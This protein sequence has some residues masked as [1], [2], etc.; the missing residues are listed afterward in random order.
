MGLFFLSACTNGGNLTEKWQDIAEEEG[1][2]LQAVGENRNN[3]SLFF[4][5][6][7]LTAI[8]A[9]TGDHTNI[10]PFELEKSY[11][12]YEVNQE[13]DMITIK[14]DGDL[15]YDLKITAKRVFI[16]QENDLEYRTETYLLEDNEQDLEK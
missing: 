9:G 2:Y 14:A 6:N 12:D 4:G 15:N 16:D 8:I 1:F 3:Y 11:P 13:E 7:G 5:E 10:F